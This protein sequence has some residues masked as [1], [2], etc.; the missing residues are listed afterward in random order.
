MSW[1]IKVGGGDN[2]H[3]A[4][5]HHHD[6][7]DYHHDG[8]DRDYDGHESWQWSYMLQLSEHMLNQHNY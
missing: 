1:L 2:H 7:G 3:D 5:D 8:V 6:A 4:G